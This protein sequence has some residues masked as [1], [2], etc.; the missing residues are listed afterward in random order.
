MYFDI[1]QA[2]FYVPFYYLLCRP[3]ICIV[4]TYTYTGLD[5]YYDSI[6][7]YMYVCIHNSQ[8]KSR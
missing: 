5:K 7:V 4:H 8:V 6:Y 1:F 3:Y 2:E